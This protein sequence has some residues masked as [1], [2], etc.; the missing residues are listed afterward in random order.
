M[1]FRG[2]FAIAF[3]LAVLLH[4]GLFFA[5]RAFE[6]RADARVSEVPVEL[7]IAESAKASPSRPGSTHVAAAALRTKGSSRAL[8]AEALHMR[9]SEA[10][11][12]STDAPATSLG[13]VAV[14][15][16]AD[17][18]VDGIAPEGE[19]DLALDWKGF[20][21]TFGER[22][23]VE[24]EA[25]AE[26]LRQKRARGQAFGRWHRLVL[27]ALGDTRH[28]GERGA[29]LTSTEARRSVAQYLSILD[30]RITPAFNEFLYAVGSP[31]DL[32]H[33]RVQ[34]SVLRY[35]PFYV[36]PPAGE[37]DDTSSVLAKV[38]RPARAEFSLL[39]S[40]ALEE[41]H[42]TATSGSSFFDA[43]AVAAI[44]NG[45]PFPPPPAELLSARERAFFAWGFDRDWKKNGLAAAEHLVV[46]TA[47]EPSAE[48]PQVEGLSEP[49]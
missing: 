18:G 41:I 31:N 6:P 27:G 38:A 20:E 43:S 5:A 2:A 37:S 13:A 25:H 10:V 19:L 30:S 9:A 44:C 15:A 42:L 35:N 22:A 7:R 49:R 14:G 34:R 8:R 33:G 4:I 36:P 3:A 47:R 1:R 11:S 46:M 32:L 16:T 45:S 28:F 21:K 17:A 26:E 29:P 48:V 24:R 40:G 23:K 39:P 12:P